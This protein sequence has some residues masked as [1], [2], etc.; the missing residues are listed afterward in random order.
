MYL[1]VGGN[2]AAARSFL[3]FLVNHAKQLAD[4]MNGYI[5]ITVVSQCIAQ[6]CYILVS[7]VAC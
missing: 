6:P 7:V 4:D 1:W 2:T 3:L 5:A